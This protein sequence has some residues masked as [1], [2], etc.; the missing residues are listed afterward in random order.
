MSVNID[1]S[2]GQVQPTGIHDPTRVPELSNRLDPI[3]QDTDIP[4]KTR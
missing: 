2:W 4:P 1:E 3:A